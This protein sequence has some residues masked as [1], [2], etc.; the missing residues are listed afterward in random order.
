MSITIETKARSGFTTLALA[1]LR[2]IAFAGVLLALCSIPAYAA[3]TITPTS[4]NVVG[5]DSNDPTTGPDTSAA[6]D[7]RAVGE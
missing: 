1:K 6:P 5:L 7:T 3:V 4:W 2:L